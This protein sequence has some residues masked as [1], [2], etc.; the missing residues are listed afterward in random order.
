[1]YDGT[2]GKF[3]RVRGDLTVDNPSHPFNSEPHGGDQ[4]FEAT[5]GMPWVQNPPCQTR[6]WPE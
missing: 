1:M 2:R 4:L 5:Y 6:T 3:R